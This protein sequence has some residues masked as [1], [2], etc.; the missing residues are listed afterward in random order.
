MLH[1][2]NNFIVS[3]QFRKPDSKIKQQMLS[4]SIPESN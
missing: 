3:L 1:Y 2:I 4:V